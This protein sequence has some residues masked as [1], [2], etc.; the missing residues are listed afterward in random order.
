MSEIEEWNILEQDTL[1]CGC[2][3]GRAIVE[4]TKTVYFSPCNDTCTNY[5][6]FLQLARE[7]EK[8][9]T[10]IEGEL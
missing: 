1:P 2:I 10:E 7:S 9:M 5:E 4:G 6:D 8:P 3:I